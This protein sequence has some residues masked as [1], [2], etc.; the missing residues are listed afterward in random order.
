LPDW[1][2]TKPDAPSATTEPGEEESAAAEP[3]TA[4][5][6][7]RLR[8]LWRELNPLREAPAAEA[9]DGDH[10]LSLARESL[11]ELLQ[12]NRVPPQVREALAEEYR[13]VE[14][15]LLR[16]EQGHLQIAAFGRVSV[17]KSAM[18][19]AL[20]GE[21]RFRT[22][23]LHGETKTAQSGRWE[24]YD[25]HGIFLVDTP[26]INEVDGETRERLA[27][28][29]AARSDLVLFVVD[30]DLTETERAALAELAEQH[31][32]IVLVL[33]KLDRYTQRD[34][35]A[36]FES[37]RHHTE[38]L[39]DP[40]NIVGAAAHPAER[41]VIMV[42]EA[43]NE[44]ETTR[45]PPIDIGTLK[46]RLWEILESEGKT[47]AALN[48]SL[49]AGR[50]TDQV[51]SR[52]L[53][54]KRHLGERIIRTYCVGKGVAVAFNPIPVADLIAAAAVDISLVV[55]LSNLYGFP[56]NR[57]EAGGLVKTIG[58][59]MMLLMGTVWAVHL[60]SSA[61][62]L[63]T[64]GLSA[65]VTGGA[66]GA[67]AYY[68]TYVVGQAAERYL[69]QG[70]SWG[71]GGPKFVVREILDSLDRD[72]IIDQAKRDIRARLSGAV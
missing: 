34:R 64:S 22:S 52:I 8:Q 32:P 15:M 6:G 1:P 51:S 10:H 50:L 35:E 42:D 72:S 60:A 65:V 2:S 17:G 18:L 68:S 21:E 54:A 66:Q 39:I 49:F 29:V 57:G 44:T 37:L 43:G 56:L 19:N 47:L 27:K 59:Q 48:A 33:N 31:R 58:A 14:Q 23:P 5:L 45:Q 70:K 28:E 20:L 16:L 7:E 4:P 25:A 61:L 9:I 40:R 63:G 38:G 55:H 24:E 11:R 69:A 30:G 46:Q 41:M 62:K 3:A 36:L 53:E 13:E 12:D 71:E 26:G 67:V